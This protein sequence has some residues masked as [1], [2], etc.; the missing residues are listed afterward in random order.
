[1]DGTEKFFGLTLK[2]L[3]IGPDRQATNRHDEPPSMSPRSAGVGQR[4]FGN[5]VRTLANGQ[6]DSVLSADGRRPARPASNYH[7]P[8]DDRYLL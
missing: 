2:L 5:H 7:W 3:Q 1:V 8:D 4:R 6:V